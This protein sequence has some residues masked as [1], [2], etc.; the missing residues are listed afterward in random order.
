MGAMLASKEVF[1]TNRCAKFENI[2]LRAEIK[3]VINK[4]GL[5]TR[6]VRY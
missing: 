4:N 5:K 6:I 1:I 2:W 3:Q